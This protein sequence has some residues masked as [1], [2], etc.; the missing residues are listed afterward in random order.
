[1]R[2][3]RTSKRRMQTLSLTT[4]PVT[5]TTLQLRPTPRGRRTSRNGSWR[6]R[7]PRACIRR[8]SPRTGCRASWN[9]AAHS[10][11][12][13]TLLNSMRRSGLTRAVS[14]FPPF[15]SE[16]STPSA[17]TVTTCRG[18]SPSRALRSGESC[19]RPSSPGIPYRFPPV[20]S[21]R[22]KTTA[23]VR[24]PP[25]I[26]RCPRDFTS[27]AATTRASYIQGRASACP[28]S[29]GSEARS[30]PTETPLRYARSGDPRRVSISNLS[31]ENAHGS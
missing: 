13:W 20:A 30:S 8:S 7:P 1:M 25:P 9:S 6:N 21:G 23:F 5:K 19:P 17:W 3:T 14:I 10:M 29:S 16:A 22:G 2:R 31:K 28:I 15:S 12:P 11:F 27:G 26:S 18:C 4:R 24:S